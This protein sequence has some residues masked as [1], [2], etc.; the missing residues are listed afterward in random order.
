MVTR[1][2]ANRADW[3]MEPRYPLFDQAFDAMRKILK[4]TTFVLAFILVP[5]AAYCIFLYQELP[6]IDDLELNRHDSAQTTL[7]FG[8]IPESVI[9]AFVAAEDKRFF[10]HNGVD[11][12]A[13][14]RAFALFAKAGEPVS[15]ASTIT[16]Q[17][18]KNRF[19]GSEKTF[20]RKLSEL[21]LAPKLEKKF[22]KMEI[23]E[24][25]LSIIY[26]GNGSYGVE[27]AAK[28]YFGKSLTELNLSE[29]AVL[30]GIPKAPSQLNPTASP[31]AA[32]ASRDR[33]LERMLGSN[34]I[35]QA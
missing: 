2:E 26:F 8:E 1:T 13:A 27:A 19:L 11:Y 18:A 6:A 25:Y 14:L 31:K 20:K 30:A 9:S 12:V 15:G 32:L 21:M 22:S 4:L 29:T 5:L 28:Q 35:D 3:E 17:L 34:F 10:A 33:V 24:S 7:R 16:M 23:M